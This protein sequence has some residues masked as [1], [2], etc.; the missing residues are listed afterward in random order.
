MPFPGNEVAVTGYC[1]SYS[2]YCYLLTVTYWLH[3]PYTYT[4]TPIPGRGGQ[5]FTPGGV[6]LTISAHFL[7]HIITNYYYYLLLLI[8]PPY[9]PSFLLYDT[10]MHRATLYLVTEYRALILRYFKVSPFHFSIGDRLVTEFVRMILEI[11]EMSPA[12]QLF[13]IPCLHH[14][15]RYVIYIS[16]MYRCIT[17]IHSI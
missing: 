4:R 10:V 2:C 5:V 17:C 16:Y 13:R 6:S 11:L 7:Y 8:L 12:P 3:G 1:Y 15:Y 9:P 14:L